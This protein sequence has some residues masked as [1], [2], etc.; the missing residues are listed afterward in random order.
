MTQPSGPDERALLAT[1]RERVA[2]DLHDHVIQRLFAIGLGL[3]NLSG[4][5]VDEAQ[6]QRLEE[7]VEQIDE[8]ILDLRAA[9]FD[10]R[11]LAGGRAASLRHRLRDIA[12]T[13]PETGPTVVIRVE[14]P[15][16]T[17]VTGALRDHAEAVVREAVSNAVRH[18]HA[19]AVTVLVAATPSEV[20]L[21]ISDNG[22]GI[23]AGVPRSGLRHIVDRA[24]GCGG[25]TTID[26]SPETGTTITWR[27][28][29][30]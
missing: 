11:S 18:A 17:L 27:V 5:V 10:L 19:T 14:G 21:V 26:T 25:S 28:P 6:R 7:S 3:Q 13:A 9:I 22:G 24:T 8:A 16:D 4:A 1:E 2:R 15:V 29:L 30:S 12:T 23:P 20:T